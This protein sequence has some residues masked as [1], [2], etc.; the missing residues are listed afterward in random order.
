MLKKHHSP[1]AILVQSL[2]FALEIHMDIQTKEQTEERR[3]S[4][5]IPIYLSTLFLTTVKYHCISFV[6]ETT[7]KKK[8]K[9]ETLLQCIGCNKGQFKSKMFN[10]LFSE[11]IVSIWS[12]HICMLVQ[13]PSFTFEKLL[14]LSPKEENLTVINFQNL[15]EFN[16][17]SK[18]VYDRH[19]R[20]SRTYVKY[21]NRVI[22]NEQY[23]AKSPH[24]SESVLVIRL[25]QE[26]AKSKIR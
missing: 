17:I 16:Y 22:K 5:L 10:P 23:T 2:G 3:A 8:K 6:R 9:K 20:S 15:S 11:E 12:K 13:Q 4:R 18:Q 1:A 21:K 26:R 7:A 14:Y 19:S 24:A 25:H